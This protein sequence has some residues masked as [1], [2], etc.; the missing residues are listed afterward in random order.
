MKVKTSI[1]L[2]E[3]ALKAIQEHLSKSSSRSDFIEQAVWAMISHLI[4]NERNA[5]DLDIINRNA[6]RLNKEALDALEY[7]V[8]V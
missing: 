2:S 8:S 3:E 4:R 5:R 1:T 6:D 7:Q